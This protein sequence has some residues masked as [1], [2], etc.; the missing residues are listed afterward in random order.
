MTQHI[1]VSLYLIINCPRLSK[2]SLTLWESQS[3]I[4]FFIGGE[5]EPKSHIIGASLHVP[6]VKVENGLITK[7]GISGFHI[8]YLGER[9]SH[10]ANMVSND[11]FEAIMALMIYG[12]LLFP[13]F[14]EFFD[15]DAIRF[16]MTCNMVPTLLGD[17][18]YSIHFRTEKNGG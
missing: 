14:K 5:E 8:K 12:I 13:R 7:G 18:Y 16:F 17:V 9:A 6:K 11:V 4:T 2:N 10:Y 1:I 3:L 15:M